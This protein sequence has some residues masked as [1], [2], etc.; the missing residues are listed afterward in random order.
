[1]ISKKIMKIFEDVNT[2]IPGIGIVLISPNEED[3]LL[4][5]ISMVEDGGMVMQHMAAMIHLLQ[6]KELYDVVLD[7]FEKKSQEL[8]IISEH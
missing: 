5:N 7:S 1:M 2:E 6:N 3:P 4:T 8:Q